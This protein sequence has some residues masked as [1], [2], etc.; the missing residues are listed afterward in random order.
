MEVLDPGHRYLLASF[1][2]GEPAP[3]TFVKRNNPPEKYPGNHDAY[4]GTSIQEVLRALIN[5][6]LYVNNQFPCPETTLT[7]RL[8]RQSLKLLEARHARLHGGVLPAVPEAI[9]VVPVCPA[10]GHIRCYCV[11]GH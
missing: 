4:P 5:R 7:I 1:D 6:S 10:C 9:E 2:G 11:G 8:M 3:L